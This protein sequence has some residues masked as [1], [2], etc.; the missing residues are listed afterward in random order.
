MSGEKNW[1]RLDNAAKIFPSSCSKT[2]TKVF[3]F[4]CQLTEDVVPEI[5]QHSA[6]TTTDA[7]SIYK[8]VLERG[9]FWYYLETSNIKPVVKKEYKSICAE[10][11]H[12]NRTNLLFEVTYYK[13]RIN[14]EV[15]HS[16]SDG[17]GALHFFKALL[18]NYLSELY[19]ISIKPEWFDDSSDF[20]KSS[21]SF[22]KYYSDKKTSKFKKE[23]FIKAYRLKGL[24]YSSN[25]LKLIRGIIP[26]DKTLEKAHEYKCSLTVFLT[27]CLISAIGEEI[28]E[29]RKKKP[30]V[31]S[32]PVNL[33]K[34]FKSETARNFFATMNIAYDFSKNT[35][36][37]K[38]IIS[39]V[40]KEFE[41]KL[42]FEYISD[43]INS[44]SKTEHNAFA[45]IAPLF[46]KDICLKTAHD[47]SALEV[48]SSL[49][50]VGIVTMP[51]AFQDYIK[52]FDMCTS[53]NKISICM[54]SYKNNLSISMTSPFINSDIQRNFFC[55]LADM[56]LNVEIATNPLEFR[57]E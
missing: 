53:G 12:K 57:E 32:V 10:I 55:H 20:Q 40:N 44:F 14:L 8:S 28:P 5:L 35:G 37:F 3:R 1:N 7:F 48:T 26:A 23:K 47:I 25:Q 13:K 45:K 52:N 29:R 18:I 17:T 15:F 54:C 42:N 30:V 16:L 33:R 50:N 19:N 9:Y 41:S 56:G 49:S 51:D 36:D 24:R 46:F 39:C 27:A 4:S 2:D 43:R 22:Q 6:E 34:F 11:Y 31:I 21:D 38:S